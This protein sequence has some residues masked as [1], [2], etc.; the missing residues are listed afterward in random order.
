MPDVD[1]DEFSVFLKSKSIKTKD[2]ESLCSKF[3]SRTFGAGVDP[4]PGFKV[5]D[6]STYGD[7]TVS[8]INS[9]KDV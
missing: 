6:M 1:V 2:A 3:V 4:D 9:I 7:G 5:W 8:I